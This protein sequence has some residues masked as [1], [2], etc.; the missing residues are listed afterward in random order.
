MP[1]T[2]STNDG[3][4]LSQ[5]AVTIWIGLLAGTWL[6]A[7][8]SVTGYFSRPLEPGI[9][10]AAIGSI[11]ALGLLAALL[12]QS[13]HPHSG[14]TTT[15]LVATLTLAPTLVSGF[16]L[17]DLSNITTWIGL[18]TLAIANLLGTFAA[19]GHRPDRPDRQ[20]HQHHP[21]ATQPPESTAVVVSDSATL[22]PARHAHILS[23][24]LRRHR[25]C[26][27]DKLEGDLTVHWEIGQKQ[28]PVHVPFVPAFLDTPEVI[29]QCE[30]D[31]SL[32]TVRVRIAEVRRFGTR[33]ELK[34]SRTI[35]TQH[36]TRLRF[37]VTLDISA[38]RAA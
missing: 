30:D 19:L 34:R 18:T 12:F 26:D 29:C 32:E 21:P 33:I 2:P 6:I 4:G 23:Q 11:A 36:A 8:R 15:P 10:W 24:N 7:T 31:V 16:A 5:L 3:L 9:A 38:R 25:D 1:S 14:R 28:Q 27:T 17:L 22:P 35:D 13:R 37:S 20:Q